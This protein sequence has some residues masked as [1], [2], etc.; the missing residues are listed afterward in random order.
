MG[1][2]KH[3]NSHHPISAIKRAARLNWGKEILSL[4][5]NNNKQ[6]MKCNCCKVLVW[7]RPLWNVKLINWIQI[8]FKPTNI[9]SLTGWREAKPRRAEWESRTSAP[10]GY[11]PNC[12]FGNLNH[13]SGHTWRQGTRGTDK[14]LPPYSSMPSWSG[15]SVCQRGVFSTWLVNVF[16]V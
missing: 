12:P 7:A 3:R 11:S 15:F 5:K 9:R 6:F 16:V 14:T 8:W 13:S 2:D 4:S 10:A 1:R